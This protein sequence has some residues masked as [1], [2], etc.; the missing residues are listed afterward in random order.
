MRFPEGKA[1]CFK[2]VT[3]VG[4]LWWDAFDNIPFLPKEF[5][6]DPEGED[7]EA[8]YAPFWIYH[9]LATGN[10]EYEAEKRR[11]G[12]GEPMKADSFRM[13]DSKD[14]FVRTY[15]VSHSDDHDSSSGGSSGGSSSGGGGFSGGGS[16]R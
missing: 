12:A 7:I 2:H 11:E 10:Y 16:A 9:T 4:R 15:T 14:E 8:V 6:A 3:A 13:I 5:L 1:G